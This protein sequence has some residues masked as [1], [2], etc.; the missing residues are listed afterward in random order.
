MGQTLQKTHEAKATSLTR[1]GRLI[2]RFIV[3]GALAIV[4]GASLTL[5]GDQI[6]GYAIHLCGWPAE[7]ACETGTWMWWLLPTSAGIVAVA[8]G[9][10]L[11]AWA[12]RKGPIHLVGMAHV[13]WVASLFFV[14][15]GTGPRRLEIGNVALYAAWGGIGIELLRASGLVLFP[16]RRRVV[17]TVAFVIW[18]AYIVI[19]LALP[20][21]LE[22]VALNDV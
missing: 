10:H 15:M 3:V 6:G 9:I 22:G 4:M 1:S 18:A 19:L 8:G 17:H 13:L 14:V 11:V 21:I 16:E 5:L 12:L 7:I 2:L 20:S